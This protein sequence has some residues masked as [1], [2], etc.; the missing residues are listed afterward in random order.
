[1][2]NINN[3]YVMNE[4]IDELA[5]ILASACRL[6]P[7]C[8]RT[9]RRAV[10]GKRTLGDLSLSGGREPRARGHIADRGYT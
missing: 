1:V 8:M 6:A 7:A 2:K 3:N 4:N 9:T 10:S 5:S